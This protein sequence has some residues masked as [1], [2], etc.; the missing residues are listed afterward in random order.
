MN[1]FHGMMPQYEVKIQ[2]T[3]RVGTPPFPVVIQAG[4]SGWTLLYSDH[5]SEYEDIDDTP[6]N[7]YDKALATLNQRVEEKSVTNKLKEINDNE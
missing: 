5:S 3:V 4:D 6:E 2:K 7:N 1:R